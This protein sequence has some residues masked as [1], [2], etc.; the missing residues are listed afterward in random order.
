M[1]FAQ[2]GMHNN[3]NAFRFAFK[4]HKP[5]RLQVHFFTH[6]GTF[7]CLPIFSF[8]LFI[9]KIWFSIKSSDNRRFIEFLRR[10]NKN[11]DKQFG[12]NGKFT[13]CEV[14]LDTRTCGFIHLRNV[15]AVRFD[16]YVSNKKQ[17]CTFL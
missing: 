6:I 15:T 2:P 13:D 8:I 14:S 12:D 1:L 7:L 16:V 5:L 11:L 4:V 17:N 9:E 10:L 3:F